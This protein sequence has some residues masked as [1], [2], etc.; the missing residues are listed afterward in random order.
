M[1][2]TKI[3]KYATI[4]KTFNEKRQGYEWA[5]ESAL[6]NEAAGLFIPKASE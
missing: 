3:S 1:R 2:L 6:T 5:T 4:N